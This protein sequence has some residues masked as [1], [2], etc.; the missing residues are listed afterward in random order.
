VKQLVE[1][2]IGP[3]HAEVRREHEERVPDRLDNLV[4]HLLDRVEVSHLTAQGSQV[5]MDGPG[6][7]RRVVHRLCSCQGQAV[8]P[9]SGAAITRRLM[10]EQ[11]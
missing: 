7:R 6:G 11:Q 4:R 3:L 2:G 5:L 1:G 10:L 9:G 8:L